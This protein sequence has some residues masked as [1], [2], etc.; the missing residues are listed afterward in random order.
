MNKRNKKFIGLI[1]IS[2]LAAGIT[3]YFSRGYI[4]QALSS[5]KE[6]LKT[7]YKSYA[8]HKSLKNFLSSETKPNSVLIFEPN[9]YHHECMPGYAKYF[10]D[11][12][13]NLDVLIIKGNEDSLS[14][15]E[16]QD[17]L[18]IFTFDNLEQIDLTSDKLSNKFSNFDGDLIVW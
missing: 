18:R 8:S 9:P 17:K 13:Y 10:S 12:G 14:L 6:N 3:G 7:V 15:F 1:A 4:T 2:I 11:L 16:P 5:Y